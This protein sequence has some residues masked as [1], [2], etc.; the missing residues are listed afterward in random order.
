MSLFLTQSDSYRE[1]N[2]NPKQK[3]TKQK[4]K[5]QT[6]QPNIHKIHEADWLENR[7]V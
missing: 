7:F 2:K 1:K 5:T 3:T 6:N 4:Q